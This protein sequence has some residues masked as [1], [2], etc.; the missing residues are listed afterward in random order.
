MWVST[1]SRRFNNFILNFDDNSKFIRNFSANFD[2]FEDWISQII[3]AWSSDKIVFVSKE[4]EIDSHIFIGIEDMQIV[5]EVKDY[6]IQ[7]FTYSEEETSRMIPVICC[8]N[9]TYKFDQQLNL[10]LNQWD[11]YFGLSVYSILIVKRDGVLKY[12]KIGNHVYDF[13]QNQIH[14]NIE[15]T[16]EIKNCCWKPTRARGLNKDNFKDVFS[17]IERGLIST[18]ANEFTFNYIIFCDFTYHPDATDIKTLW[19]LMD[20]FEINKK[21]RIKIENISIIYPKKFGKEDEVKIYA[22]EYLFV[23]EGRL[24]KIQCQNYETIWR[25]L[26]YISSDDDTVIIQWERFRSGNILIT[27]EDKYYLYKPDWYQ[28]FQEKYSSNGLDLYLIIRKSDIIEYT[29]SQ[30]KYFANIWTLPNLQKV[31]IKITDSAYEKKELVNILES[32]PKTITIEIHLKGIP[33][34]SNNEE[35]WIELYKFNKA[36]FRH[37]GRWGIT[38]HTKTIELDEANLFKS[39]AKEF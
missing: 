39:K 16:C 21:S 10:R 19:K 36:I 14:R 37:D 27:L 38:V 1:D 32:I 28:K 26:V 35:F 24:Y 33:W 5:P 34:F 20:L 23:F 31:G 3:N 29:C 8:P 18:N 15:N 12:Q 30:L 4:I 7:I 11:L 9:F 13:D 2:W 25:G 17:A 6:W 22:K